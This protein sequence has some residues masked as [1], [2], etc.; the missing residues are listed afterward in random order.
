M[1]KV[2][3]T[4]D[5]FMKL[6][7]ETGQGQ[8][9]TLLGQLGKTAAD[10]TV[11]EAYDPA[12]LLVFKE[13]LF[14]VAGAD[15]VQLLGQWVSS[16]QAATANRLQVSNTTVAGRDLTRIVDPSRQVATTTYA[17]A[18]GDTLWLILADETTLL[19]EALGKVE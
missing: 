11:A 1:E 19:E 7:G 3:L 10:L 13:G 14:R 2:R 15:P 12:G 18:D 5:D 4:G 8:M 17:F 9:T 6:G 16:Q